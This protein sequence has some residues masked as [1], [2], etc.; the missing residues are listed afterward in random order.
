MENPSSLLIEIERDNSALSATRGKIR[1]FLESRKWAEQDANRVVLAVDEALANTIEHG[2][3]LN[4]HPESN[5][6]RINLQEDRNV[7][8]VEIMD[9]CQ[10]FDPTAIEP[11]DPEEFI[12]EGRDGGMGI[13]CFMSLM[14]VEYK[15]R[16]GGLGNIL[17]FR[18]P[19][20]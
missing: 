12:E 14:D 18:Y 1:Q 8:R 2:I 6:V 17:V 9:S 13:F 10:P 3:P 19:K 4:S 11:A 7:I 16:E 15:L 5:R 20:S